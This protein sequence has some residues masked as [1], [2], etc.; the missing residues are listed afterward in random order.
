M[1]FQ[2]WGLLSEM[3]PGG[4]IDEKR[5]DVEMVSPAGL[6]PATCGLGNRRSIQMSYGDPIER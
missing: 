6:E 1:R 4:M 2:R 3:R 5:P